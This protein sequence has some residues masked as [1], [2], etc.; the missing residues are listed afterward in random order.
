M[1]SYFRRIGTFGRDIRLFLVFNLLIYVGFG[2][3]VLVFNLYLYELDLREDFIGAFSAIQTLTTAAAALTMG[4]PMA[5]F[6]VWRCLTVSAAV[7]LVVSL[8]LA[9]VETPAILL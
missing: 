9:F 6:G 8:A 4:R 1:R 3:P 5:R 2:V 7:Y